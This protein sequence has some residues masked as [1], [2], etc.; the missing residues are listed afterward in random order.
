MQMTLFK[1]LTQVEKILQ[2]LKE[3]GDKGVTNIQLNE[4][5]FRY[6][7]RL[8]DLR[9]DGYKIQATH[10]KDSIWKFTLKED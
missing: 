9:R 7:A 2:L 4:I 10:I 1:P 3:A 5:A 6:S 8:N